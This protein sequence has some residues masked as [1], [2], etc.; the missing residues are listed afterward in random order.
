[1]VVFDFDQTLS[2]IHVFKCLAG[3]SEQAAAA[4]IEKPF[5]CTERGQLRKIEELDKLPSFKRLGGFAVVA[6]GGQERVAQLR[7]LLAQLKLTEVDMFI[8][9]KGL[10]GPVCKCLSDV[11]LL[12]FFTEVYGNIGSEYGETPF[13]KK[14]EPNVELDKFL[15]TWEQAG[16][17]SKDKL[18]RRLMDQRHLKEDQVVLVEDDQEEVR[19][20]RG[21]CRTVFVREARG[22][23]TE[24]FQRLLE[25]TAP[26]N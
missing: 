5:A 20:A 9:S 15:G 17:G 14:I 24:H 13:D 22:M 10:V 3:W 4:M 11:G 16:W 26:P 6:L 25:M 7:A 18:I 23:T 8:C 2:C 21:T 1:M 12:A 19:R